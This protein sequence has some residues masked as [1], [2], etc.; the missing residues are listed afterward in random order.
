MAV[1]GR[2]VRVGGLPVDMP[3]NRLADKLHIHFL[4]RKNGGGEI[5][6]VNISESTPGTA[7]ITFEEKEVAWKLAKQGK[8]VV[9]LN[10]KSYAV[11][12][13]LHCEEMDPDEI[14][15]DMCVTVD[16]SKLPEGRRTLLYLHE[17]FPGVHLTFEPQTDLCTLKGRYSE[18]RSLCRL[19]LRSLKSQKQNS[20]DGL[21]LKTAGQKKYGLPLVEKPD[22]HSVEASEAAG[23]TKDA[24]QP[25]EGL[26]AESPVWNTG[27]A[28][29]SSYLHHA[30]DEALTED[31]MGPEPDDETNFE[32]FSMVVDSDIFRYLH[33]YCN[34]E[35][36]GLLRRHRVEVVDVTSEDITTLYLK[37]KKSLSERGTSSVRKAQQQLA[38]L[39]QEKGSQLRKENVSTS[40]IPKKDLTHA[41]ES[42][43]VRM[44]QLMMEEDKEN[45]W[46]VGSK[47]DVSEAKQ[48][49]TDVKGI[50][51][52]AETCLNYPFSSSLPSLNQG[53]S[54]SSEYLKSPG[55]FKP[56]EDRF[57]APDD[58]FN[59]RKDYQKHEEI[60]SD[61]K[62]FDDH[63]EFTSQAPASTAMMEE[64]L[65]STRRTFDTSEE[66]RIQSDVKRMERSGWY[67]KDKYTDS[68]FV[69]AKP[70]L[71]LHRR[72]LDNPDFI[73][74][75]TKDT[76]WQPDTT[77]NGLQKQP[78]SS[79]ERLKKGE[80]GRGLR[81]AP[82]FSKDLSSG[83][84]D[85]YGDKKSA[86][87]L[88]T[89]SPVNERTPPDSRQ[90]HS[91]P[92]IKPSMNSSLKRNTLSGESGAKSSGLSRMDIQGLKGD[93][94]KPG[95]FSLTSAERKPTVMPAYSTES[96]HFSLSH[97]DLGG[98]IAASKNPAMPPGSARRRSNSFSGK[99]K[100]GQDGPTAVELCSQTK[101]V[102]TAD[103]LVSSRLWLYLKSVYNTELDNLTSD[104]QVKEEFDKKDL[105]LCLRGASSEKVKECHRGLKSLIAR[106]EKDFDARALPLDKLGLSDC[107]DERVVDF[108]TLMKQM[109][110]KVKIV[111]MS[112]SVMILGPKSTCKEVEATMMEVFR[113]GV[114]GS[115]SKTE[116]RKPNKPNDQEVSTDPTLLVTDRPTR[117]NESAPD[118]SDKDQSYKNASNQNDI[119]RDA[120]LEATEREPE[121]ED[122]SDK[123]GYAFRVHLGEKV[124]S[125]SSI[126]LETERQADGHADGDHSTTP[127][128]QK[129]SDI[130][131]RTF[132]EQATPGISVEQTSDAAQP[133]GV[134]EVTRTDLPSNGT[135]NQGLL[136]SCVCGDQNST[137]RR[138]ACGRNF[139]FQC[140][141]DDVHAN[142]KLC[143]PETRN[144]EAWGIKGT[145]SVRE[146]TI[147]I[148][149]FMRDTTA[150]LVYDIPDGIQGE[151]HPCPG[152]PFKGNRFEA[153][154]PLNADTKKL[155]PLL[156]KAF[157]KGLIF[158]VKAGLPEQQGKDG[159]RQWR[160]SWGSIPHK[161][162][163]DGGTS[164]NGY[165]D[166]AYIRRLAEAL[167]NAGLEE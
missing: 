145:M 119:T 20:G 164:K 56:L 61:L 131:G 143:P 151:G 26:K 82:N 24:P 155:L 30:S 86:E 120:A 159:D 99:I 32:D 57:K 100:K 84:M 109:H 36:Q 96:Q 89:G 135:G 80:S 137:V 49:I 7:F 93:L 141:K 25:E 149:G 69:S 153:Y 21:S 144:R 87:D 44:P 78:K 123:K 112:K 5:S 111:V 72:S 65:F 63:R 127:T 19:V 75:D 98:D 138:A 2:T 106:I 40:G 160:V 88:K 11:T 128:L 74:E 47:S 58:L 59:P 14:V 104:L 28:Q 165:P 67:D 101:E 95:Q 156:D 85:S 77:F 54:I 4:R 113:T 66:R 52:D 79:K 102:F 46:M 41:L 108:C 103:V 91:L 22:D 147:T 158:T 37:P 34:K 157:Q 134:S 73:L 29:P 146:S 51:P 139:C 60:H 126:N 162:S 115:T 15:V 110:E 3:E 16:H 150:K 10:D 122:S 27:L 125:D 71:D 140:Q 116:S 50:R 118:T 12:V 92:F 9:K 124:N 62:H 1:E 70:S 8:Q 117:T 76:K 38:R 97:M 121:A 6:S 35:Y 136:L 23:M 81:M 53:G 90:P 163:L 154:L 94:K 43:R 48:F 68:L 132:T 107:T 42:L 166:S 17:A 83:P 130:H 31:R 114:S 55:S 45:V 167:R 142:C 148:P 39:Y 33:K 13:S 161:T 64:D 18:V 152:E 133:L 105:T 129:T